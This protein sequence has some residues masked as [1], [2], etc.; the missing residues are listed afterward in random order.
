MPEKAENIKKLQLQMGLVRRSKVSLSINTNLQSSRNMH[1]T[2]TA[3]SSAKAA[4]S[5]AFLENNKM[6]PNFALC[7][8]NK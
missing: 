6:K 8:G 5:K 4:F 1:K 2:V 3:A 7:A